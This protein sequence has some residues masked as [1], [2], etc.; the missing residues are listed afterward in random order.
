MSLAS[1]KL[2]RAANRAYRT[3]GNMARAESLAAAI[4]INHPNSYEA[5]HAR[6]L[7]SLIQRKIAEDSRRATEAADTKKLQAVLQRDTTAYT[8]DRPGLPR[9]YVVGNHIRDRTK[10]IRKHCFET[11]F[12]ELRREP[13]NPHDPNAVA[14]WV[15]VPSF[16]SGSK[17]KQIGYLKRSHAERI[18]K[19]L[20]ANYKLWAQIDEI[21][22]PEGWKFPKVKLNVGY[23]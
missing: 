17:Q 22:D 10:V 1:N 19:V 7:Q 18:A 2:L 14:V 11:K 13:N 8:T 9:C 16:F 3:E 20:D 21:Y 12:V 4:L 6:K 23:D 15:S 5:A